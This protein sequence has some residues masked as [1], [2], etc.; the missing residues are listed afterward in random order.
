LAIE[1]RAN[2]KRKINVWWKWW[3][4]KNLIIM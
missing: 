3:M 2:F 1:K 4:K